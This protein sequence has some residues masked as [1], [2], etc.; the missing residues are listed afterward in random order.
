MPRRPG[1]HMPPVEAT[2]GVPVR[3]VLGEQVAPGV[4]KRRAGAE[5]TRPVVGTEGKLRTSVSVADD[6]RE[7]QKKKEAQVTATPDQ[8]KAKLESI[9]K[10]TGS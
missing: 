8:A 1:E 10:K 7:F 5:R 3:S 4:V 9:F 6:L 2:R